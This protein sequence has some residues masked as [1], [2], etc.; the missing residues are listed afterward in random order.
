[1][2]Y[3]QA[4]SQLC[5]LKNVWPRIK[6][7]IGYLGIRPNEKCVI[8]ETSESSKAHPASPPRKSLSLGIALPCNGHPITVGGQRTCRKHGPKLKCYP[9]E[10]LV[11]TLDRINSNLQLRAT[12]Y[13]RFGTFLCF[14]MVHLE[15]PN[16][17]CLT[18]C[19][20][21]YRLVVFFYVGHFYVA[22][23]LAESPVLRI[24][25]QR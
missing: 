13:Q 11:I 17:I 21:T 1:M 7:T 6:I 24:W 23:A 4:F 9:P 14:R 18:G 2:F 22:Q 20:Q 12:Q 5:L 15:S 10:L 16:H 8:V 3:V 19:A 25:L